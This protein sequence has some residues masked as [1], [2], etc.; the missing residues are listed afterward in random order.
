SSKLVLCFCLTSAGVLSCVHITGGFSPG[1][2]LTTTVNA[3]S[4]SSLSIT[5][6]PTSFLLLFPFLSVTG[7]ATEIRVVDEKPDEYSLNHYIN[8]GWNETYVEN[9]L[10]GKVAFSCVHRFTSRGFT[11]RSLDLSAEVKEKFN[12]LC[13]Q[14]GILPENIVH[15]PKTA[16]SCLHPRPPPLLIII[17]LI[18]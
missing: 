4:S 8:T 17:H 10:Y 5:F 2:I 3:P 16:N 1:N 18:A 11:G 13:L 9:N 15:L 12:Q 14:S 7:V 6:F